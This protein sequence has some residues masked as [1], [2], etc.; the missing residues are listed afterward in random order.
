MK[1]ICDRG[2]L[3]DALNLVG[4][5]IV[6]RTP[7]PVLKCVKIT[8]DAESATLSLAGTDLEVGV[9]VS[10]PRV[11]I[12]QGGEALLPA[13]T[14]T[15]IVRES[16]DPTLTI[17][18]EEDAAHIRSADSRFKVF[19][20]PI[21]DFPPVGRFTGEPDFEL[22]ASE[23]HRLI[24][25][26]IFATARESSRYAINGVLLER[27][28]RKLAVVATDGRR[29]A[30]ARGECRKAKSDDEAGV[31]HS[32]IVPTKALTILL[33]LF[34]D[35]ETTVRLR[36]AENQIF[37][38]SDDAVLTS[39]LVEGNFPPYRDVIPRDGDRKATLRSDLLASAV[40]RAALLTNEDSKGVRLAFGAEGLRLTS[41][42]PEMGEA[43][44]D[45]ELAEYAGEPI[46]IGFNPQFITDALKVTDAEQVSIE[47][48]APNKPGVLR[49]DS[50][51]LYVIMPVN[52]Q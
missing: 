20:Q 27:E 1:V 9:R 7:K 2:A 8:A 25:Q 34:T 46:E 23:L 37:F 24:S 32:A 38:A 26:T 29:L 10:S 12:E 11:E 42:A 18:M 48:K 19:G 16:L 35:A 28:G 30:L 3:A 21:E 44:V 47:M 13:E 33:R 14:L 51:F 22:A 31:R 41:R 50:G 6:S 49:A 52:L 45:V 17:E 4:A 40:R 43:E 5:V 36:I 39:N 15:Q